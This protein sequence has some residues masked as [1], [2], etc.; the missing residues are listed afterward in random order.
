MAYVQVQE[1]NTFIGE[2][3]LIT[4]PQIVR[5]VVN[6]QPYMAFD[7]SKLLTD[8]DNVLDDTL[9]AAVSET[10]SKTITFA[11]ESFSSDNKIV[12]FKVSSFAADTFTIKCSVRTT[13]G[14]SNLVSLIGTFIAT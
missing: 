14:T 13:E 3:G 5:G 8:P 11:D 9:G 7:F 4:C 1:G 12:T 6:D 10:G 2:P